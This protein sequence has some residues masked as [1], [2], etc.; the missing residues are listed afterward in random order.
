MG[1][2]KDFRPSGV[3]PATLMAFHDDYAIDE[4]SARRHLADVGL[5]RGVTAVTVNG[6]ASEVHACTFEEQK[7]ILAFSLEE[8]GD[9]VPLING[10]YADGS[11]EAARIARMAE[12]AGASALLVFPPQ[13]M[14]MGGQLRPE[15]AVA[16][17]RT[18]ADATD[19]P[20]IL[21][22]YPMA[23]GLGY[24]Y[25]TLLKILDAVPSI[26]A[27]KD[28][29][30]D[31]ALHERHTRTLQSMPRPITVLTT[32]SAWLMSSLVLGCNGLLSGAGSVIA[33]LQV[34]LFDAVQAK[35]L[36]AAQQINDRI[37]PLAQAFYAPPF[38]DM[39]NRM[40]ECL[41]LL[42][43]LDKAVVRPPLMK[44]SDAEIRRLKGALAEAGIGRDGAFGHAQAAE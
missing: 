44:L 1:R 15:M 17:F 43:R 42:G 33:D 29:S 35:D 23:S 28:W 7:R 22:Q 10:V 25:E 8:I 32:H 6:H 21:F 13:S 12:D 16:H 37:Y 34:A 20:I 5:T 24:P 26:V 40:K 9:R 19:L 41:V 4:P 14:T 31:G 11:L 27:I 30:G 36:A 38:L 3:I 39:H 2:F 18:I